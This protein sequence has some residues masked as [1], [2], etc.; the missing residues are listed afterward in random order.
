MNARRKFIAKIVQT[1]ALAVLLSHSLSRFSAPAACDTII[2]SV[3]AVRFTGSAA[4]A[5]DPRIKE[6]VSQIT[7]HHS[8][9]KDNALKIKRQTTKSTLLDRH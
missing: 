3:K 8:Y 1:P 7:Q 9:F 2:D 4:Y 5:H 6:M